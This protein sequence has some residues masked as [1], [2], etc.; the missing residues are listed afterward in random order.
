MEGALLEYKSADTCNL[1]IIPVGAPLTLCAHLIHKL[2]A[3]GFPRSKTPLNLQHLRRILTRT[4]GKIA[5]KTAYKR[6][7]QDV[8]P[9]YLPRFLPKFF[10]DL[11][12][13]FKINKLLS[14]GFSRGRRIDQKRKVPRM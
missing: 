1:A 13:Y 2:N 14:P 5:S 11:T 9:R 3:R 10:Q 8:L 4:S 12:R 7:C 6:C